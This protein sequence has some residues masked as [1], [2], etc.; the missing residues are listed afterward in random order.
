M[1]S[2]GRAESE[3]GENVFVSVKGK[4]KSQGIFLT[5]GCGKFDGLLT[6]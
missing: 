6:S 5:K 1:C 4:S 3:V 2:V